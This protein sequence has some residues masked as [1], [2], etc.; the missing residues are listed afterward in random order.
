VV[1]GDA[2]I[3]I[4]DA[5]TGTRMAVL[6]GHKARVSR[7]DF[8]PDGKFVA[9][10]SADRIV[11]LHDAADG[12][13][14]ASLRGHE[15]PVEHVVWSPA[16]DRF[17]TAG[18]DSVRLWDRLSEG[19]PVVLR[20]DVGRIR[21]LRFGADGAT[22]AAAGTGGEVWD[23]ATATRRNAIPAVPREV[24]FLAFDPLGHRLLVAG[25]NGETHL[26][27]AASGGAVA[28]M[29]L[30]CGVPRHAALAPDGE[31]IV[32]AGTRGP[33]SLW[34]PR[35][36]RLVT[37]ADDPAEVRAVAFRP[38][39]P[40]QFVAVGAA[41][42]LVL[43]DADAGAV[44]REVDLG[45][46]FATAFACSPDGGRVAVGDRDGRLRLVDLTAG[47]SLSVSGHD[48][49]VSAVAW[50]PDGT[51]VVTGS[52]DHTVRVWDAAS[53]AALVVLEGHTGPVLD[54]AVSPDGRVVASAGADGT[55]R[56]WGPS[57]AAIAA[58]RLARGT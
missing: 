51:R 26:H 25:G 36:G 33:I 49:R 4:F 9:T 48:L 37:H 3:G 16:G 29:L 23:V 32:A 39:F 11:R 5:E 44:I 13:T 12:R 46:P 56:L 43:R 7:V 27:D 54:V 34:H 55:I 6:H 30:P 38:G 24:R 20:T 57:A 2:P 47:S 8:A 42:R 18:A 21:A 22:L 15:E 35:S 45:I 53:G 31:W 19:G 28:S 41:G 14:I 40:H 50:S 58:A 10:A 52:E 1:C 17:V